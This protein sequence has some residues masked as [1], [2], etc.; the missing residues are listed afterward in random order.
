MPSY[1][2]NYAYCSPFLEPLSIDEVVPVAPADDSGDEPEL[3]FPDPT[4]N[5]EAQI[6]APHRH[7]CVQRIFPG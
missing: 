7:L 3:D 1:W 5:A 2:D 4:W 6:E